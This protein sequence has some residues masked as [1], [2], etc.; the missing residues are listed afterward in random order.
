ME[1]SINGDGAGLFPKGQTYDFTNASGDAV[2]GEF[3]IGYSAS[4]MGA[5]ETASGL[6]F[7]L[8]LEHVSGDHSKNYSYITGVQISGSGLGYNSSFRDLKKNV[9]FRTGDMAGVLASGYSGSL[10][11]NKIKDQ[12]VGLISSSTGYDTQITEGH[13]RSIRTNL[14]TGTLSGSGAFNAA[15]GI[16]KALFTSRENVVDIVSIFDS[17]DSST[18]ATKIR[19]TGIPMVFSYTKPASDWALFTGDAGSNNLTQHT[20]TG[21]NDTSLMRY[22]YGPN[23]GDFLRAVVR[24]KNYVD[25][26]PMV[27]NLVFS[28]AD[29]FVSSSTI[30]GTVMG[31]GYD[32]PLEP[33]L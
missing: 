8:Y 25:D 14:H 13:I 15:S 9:T 12:A 27:Y 3:R 17:P 11:G 1:I 33:K 6:P 2:S 32:V 7:K 30:S 22:K 10:F 18:A 20:A 26:D 28:G 5:L 31:T 4:N 16:D 23:D 24:F 19:A 29:G 21:I